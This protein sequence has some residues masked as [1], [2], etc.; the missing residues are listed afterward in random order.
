MKIET[1]FNKGDR[2]FFIAEDKTKW[3]TCPLCKSD[4]IDNTHYRV[5]ESTVS[6][7]WADAILNDNGTATYKCTYADGL[8]YSKI[9]TDGMLYADRQSAEKECDRRNAELDDSM[10][11]FVGSMLDEL[12]KAEAKH[13]HFADRIE[14]RDDNYYEHQLASTR[15]ALAGEISV[16]E[17]SACTLL[18]CEVQEFIVEANKGDWQAALIELA[19]VGAVLI[20]TARAVQAKI[21]ERKD[22]EHA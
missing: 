5:V 6:Y 20:R 7:I 8:Q 18:L 16:G 14:C 10:Y 22:G 21:D 19:Q 2:V 9:C 17:S 11:G 13:P 4:D 3:A 1:K 15:V 12:A